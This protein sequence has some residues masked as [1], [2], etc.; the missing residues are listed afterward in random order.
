MNLPHVSNNRH[1][2][3]WCECS[4]GRKVLVMPDSLTTGRSKSCGCKK[5]ALRFK[6]QGF[7]MDGA[8]KRRIYNTYRRLAKPRGLSFNLTYEQFHRFTSLNCD[9]CGEPPKQISKSKYPYSVIPFIYNGIDR[10]NNL[11]GYTLENCVA[12]CGRCNQ[13][14]HAMTKAEFLGW[15]KQVYD[16]QKAKNE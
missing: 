12:C 14:K 13:A 7:E 10:V 1:I 2:R 6:T 3:W 5:I 4:C 9:Y 8:G 15:V 11:V 16:Y